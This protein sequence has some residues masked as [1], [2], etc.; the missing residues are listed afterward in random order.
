MIES[1][2]LAAR[3]R[4]RYLITPAAKYLVRTRGVLGAGVFDAYL[5]TQFRS[6]AG[7]ASVPVEAGGNR[8]G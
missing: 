8:P 4:S 3:P 5:R 2:I 7:V 1:A 6:G